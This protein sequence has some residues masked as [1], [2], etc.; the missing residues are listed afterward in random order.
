MLKNSSVLIEK[1]SGE[2]WTVRSRAMSNKVPDQSGALVQLY[3]YVLQNE[4]HHKRFVYEHLFA[5][6]YDEKPRAN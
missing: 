5:R 6:E 3:V 4:R 1:A 2:E